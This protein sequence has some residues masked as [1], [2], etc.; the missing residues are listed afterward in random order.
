MPGVWEM[1]IRRSSSADSAARFLAMRRSSRRPEPK[2]LATYVP[3]RARDVARPP[4]RLRP[5]PDAL[6]ARGFAVVSPNPGPQSQLVAVPADFVV[7][8]TKI[9]GGRVI[10]LP[11]PSDL[12]AEDVRR[13]HAV[14]LTFVD[15]PE[16]P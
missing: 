13:L 12:S 11:L 10:A 1:S 5:T 4:L 15:D 14:L 3:E 6:A 7:Y 9:S 2:P 8:R 16:V